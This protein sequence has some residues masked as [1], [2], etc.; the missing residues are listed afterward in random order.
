MKV[1]STHSYIPIVINMSHM[2]FCTVEFT[3]ALKTVICTIKCDICEMKAT[4]VTDF[5]LLSFDQKWG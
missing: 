5:T 1:L 4:P 2:G 3:I